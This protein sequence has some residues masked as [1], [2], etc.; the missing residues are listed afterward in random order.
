MNRRPRIALLA[1][2]V[3]LVIAA[4]VASALAWPYGHGSGRARRSAEESTTTVTTARHPATT[5][6][7]STTA[8]IPGPRLVA[9]TPT[10]VPAATAPTTSAAPSR[11]GSPWPPGTVVSSGDMQGSITFSP[12]TAPEGT[13]MSYIATIT[14]PADHWLF[15]PLSV[16]G[17]FSIYLWTPETEADDATPYIPSGVAP[18]APEFQHMTPAGPQIGLLLAPHG[19]YSF[20]G[21]ASNNVEY[22]YASADYVGHADIIFTPPGVADTVAKVARDAGTFTVLVPPATTTT[23]EPSA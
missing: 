14:N 8:V 21:R 11:A 18:T 6:H 1:G 23:T 22:D 12:V 5:R 3:A 17:A 13:V 19:S 10:A 9:H 15:V 2:G 4:V 20:A 16:W 7:P